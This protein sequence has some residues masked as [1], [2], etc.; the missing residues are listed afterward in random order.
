MRNLVIILLFLT[1]I[2]ISF[3]V[4]KYSNSPTKEIIEIHDT[5]KGD[6][7]PYKIYITK[8][9]PKN[10]ILPKDT[11]YE[12]LNI[13][14]CK[15]YSESLFK[16]L[17]SEV[18]YE[19]TLKNDTSALIVLKQSLFKN[20]I[21]STEL[22]FQNRRNTSISTTIMQQKQYTWGAGSIIGHNEISVYGEY[23]KDRISCILGY[24]LT[25]K[26]PIMGFTYKIK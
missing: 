24:N 14:S 10:I 13:D 4:G 18:Q 2:V 23:S 8:Y 9:L 7:I 1:S 21:D 16:E 15:E 12:I 25:T 3:F 5:I 20:R 19:D 26:T 22:I 17:Y 6:S 11:V